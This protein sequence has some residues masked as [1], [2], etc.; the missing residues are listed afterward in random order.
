MFKIKYKRKTDKLN[1][2]QNRRRREK[3]KLLL[4]YEFD[5]EEASGKSPFAG[6]LPC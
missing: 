5:N 3:E 1:V 6:S 2:D 4:I